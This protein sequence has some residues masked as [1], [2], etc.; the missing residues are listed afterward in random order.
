MGRTVVIGGG[1]I[2]LGCAFELLLRGEEVLVIDADEPGGGCSAG[3]AGWVVPSLSGP[4]AAPGA[5]SFALTSLRKRSPA[6]ALRPRWDLSHLSWLVTFAKRAN[7]QDYLHGLHDILRLA[8]E[9]PAAYE[10]WARHGISFEVHRQGLVFAFTS[11]AAMGHLQDTLLEIRDSG[12][13]SPEVVTGGGVQNLESALSAEVRAAIFTPEDI[14]VRPE[15]VLTGLVSRI[16]TLGGTVRSRTPAIR[17][18]HHGSD[19]TSVETPEGPIACDRVVLA[20]G[21]QSKD[22]ARPLGVRLPLEGGKGYSV[23]VAHPTLKLRHMVYLY[24]AKVAVS[25]YNQAL[26]IAGTMEIGRVDATVEPGPLTGIMEAT[27]RYLPGWEAGSHKTAWAGL[28]PVSSDTL[29]IIGRA[30]GF[31]NLFIATG[32]A[33]LGVTLAPVTA[34]HLAREIVEGTPSEALKPFS[35]CRFH[36]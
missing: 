7:R 31:R 26:R 36:R 19:V 34:A 18:D 4:L 21:V 3:N 29:P 23:T 30:P 10:E 6:F 35:P 2:G 33:M 8:V 11:L 28:R 12:F 25:P 5:I 20:A 32:H 1:I 13:G 9:A 14:H 27:N 24:E 16:S 22:L 15:S 17:I